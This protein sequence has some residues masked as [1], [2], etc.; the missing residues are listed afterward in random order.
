LAH[1]GQSFFEADPQRKRLLSLKLRELLTWEK[2]VL[3]PTLGPFDPAAFDLFDEHRMKLIVSCVDKLANYTSAEIENILESG[4][5]PTANAHG[6]PRF[7]VDE[8]SSLSRRVPPWH[9]GGFGHPDHV[10]DF[11][12]WTKMPRFRVSEL[13]ALSMGINP[14]HFSWVQLNDLSSSKNR[15]HFDKPLEWLLKRFEQLHRR[16][17][18]SGRDTEVMPLEFLQWAERFEFEVHPGF[19]VPL[20]KFHPAQPASSPAAKTKKPDKR[21]VDSIAQLFTAMAIDYL[22]YN[23]KQARSPATKEIAEFAASLGMKIS[24]DT[25]LKY[26]RIG[27]RFISEDWTPKQR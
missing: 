1:D 18:H 9:I 24:E 15:P 8:I 17:S 10:A 22:G 14:G 12:H 20:Q 19:L 27:A 11:D 13:C 26:L 25:A 6:W 5:S 4:G 7:L 16:F 2:P 23:P 3:F 21:E